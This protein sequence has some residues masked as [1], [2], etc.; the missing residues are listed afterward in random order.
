MV[1]W[2]QATDNCEPNLSYKTRHRGVCY[3]HLFHKISG[4][5]GMPTLWRKVQMGGVMKDKSN[6]QCHRGTSSSPIL[7][8]V[9]IDILPFRYGWNSW[10]RYQTWI[11]IWILPPLLSTSTSRRRQQELTQILHWIPPQFP[12]FPSVITHQTYPWCS[13]SSVYICKLCY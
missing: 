10:M 9:P 3:L 11:T 6:Q 2:A 4:M 5:L 7:F 12:Q 13:P 1:L 8:L